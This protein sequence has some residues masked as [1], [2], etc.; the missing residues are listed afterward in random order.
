MSDSTLRSLYI[1]QTQVI[2][3]DNHP[4]PKAKLLR[5]SWRSIFGHP[6]CFT[7]QRMLIRDASNLFKDVWRNEMGLPEDTDSGL[8]LPSLPFIRDL[9]S[10]CFNTRRIHAGTYSERRSLAFE[11]W[12]REEND[13]L[14]QELDCESDGSSWI[15]GYERTLPDQRMNHLCFELAKPLSLYAKTN[16]DIRANGK[17][18]IHIYPSGYFVIHLAISLMWDNPRSLSE[19]HEI[20][21]ETRPHHLSAKWNWSSRLG[22]EN[23]TL[24]SLIQ[25]VY[26]C[27]EASV[28]NETNSKLCTG[29]QWRSFLRLTMERCV[30]SQIS[31]ELFKS[32]AE[33][34]VIDNLSS[35]DS[36]NGVECLVVTRQGT[37]CIFRPFTVT[38]EELCKIYAASL[39]SLTNQ[40]SDQLTLSPLSTKDQVEIESLIHSTELL[41]LKDRPCPRISYHLKQRLHDLVPIPWDL[42]NKEKAGT[43]DEIELER[44]CNLNELLKRIDELCDLVWKMHSSWSKPQ[45]SRRFFWKMCRIQELVLVKEKIYEDY[46]CFIQEQVHQLQKHRRSLKSKITE[47]EIFKFSVFDQQVADFLPV[48]D[49]YVKQTNNFYRYIYGVLCGSTK[50]NDH[51]DKVCDLIKEWDSEAQKWEHPTSAIWKKIVQPLRA[52]LASSP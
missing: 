52:I 11:L 38:H 7:D 43:I 12:D 9:G 2:G 26:R 23:E 1:I 32:Y 30:P 37:A 8:P 41:S 21:K 14:R 39:V 31:K 35:P 18:F 42:R 13:I 10:I 25:K 15:L 45:A 49:R 36:R 28:F 6:Q 5:P 33:P 34:K 40:V 44:L 19:V 17:I 51:R 47:E 46:S 50:I 48:L 16:S 27:I 3:L 4:F 24:H 22:K 29:G 20:L